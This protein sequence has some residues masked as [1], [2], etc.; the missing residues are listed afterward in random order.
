MAPGGGS[1]RLKASLGTGG[2][3]FSRMVQ[4]DAPLLAPELLTAETVLPS[5]R[6]VTFQSD[7]VRGGRTGPVPAWSQRDAPMETAAAA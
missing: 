7:L 4:E 5:P 6:G 1:H 2:S 3:E